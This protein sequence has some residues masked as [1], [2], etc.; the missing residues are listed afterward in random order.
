VY[1]NQEFLFS[2]MFWKHTFNRMFCKDEQIYVFQ[3]QT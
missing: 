1:F 3:I 2:K